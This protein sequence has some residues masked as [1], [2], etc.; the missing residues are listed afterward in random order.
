MLNLF[1]KNNEYISCEW[2]ESGISFTYEGI[3][4]CCMFAHNTVAFKPVTPINKDWTYDFDSF[5]KE[6]KKFIKAHRKGQIIDRCLGCQRLEKRVWDNNF[7]IKQLA[8]STNTKCNAN[9]IYCYTHK[10]KDFFNNI[11]D[12]P[13]LN[14]LKKCINA[15]LI[16]ENVSVLF[17]G[18]E[19]TINN[20]FE[21]I[22]D[23]FSKNSKCKI[24]IYS[25]GI[26]YSKAIENLLRAGN[27]EL[28]ITPDCGDR[29][30]YKKIK[31]VD[32][33]DEVWS[34]IQNYAAAQNKNKEQVRTKYIILPN[35]ND[36]EEEIKKFFNKVIE[37]NVSYI[38]PEIDIT[39]YLK[40][41]QDKEKLEELFKLL[42]FMEKYAEKRNINHGLAGNM[43]C[44]VEEHR[45]LYD[46]IKNE[47]KED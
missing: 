4:N 46:K 20:E 41:K 11:N 36:N 47:Y 31:G 10:R 8:I 30:L 34:N 9:C 15:N 25:S 7:K 17:G 35:I 40:I 27:C 21:D 23:L 12:I 5:I 28:V 45:N 14:F 37:A 44:A 22:M 33:F 38:K 24:K 13:I 29:Q 18:G 6:K 32:K 2:L 39:S 19:P 1:K 26:K 16:D 43:H 42:V 3:Y